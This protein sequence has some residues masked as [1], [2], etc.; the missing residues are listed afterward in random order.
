[1]KKIDI[2]K[3]WLYQ[4]YVIERLT[5]DDFKI[6]YGISQRTISRRIKEFN[7]ERE[8]SSWNSGLAGTGICKAPPKCFKKGHIPWN[9]DSKGL[10]RPNKT[11]FKK[12][13]S[14]TKG[15]FKKRDP[16][17]TGD[18]NKR[19]KGGITPLNNK[20]RHCDEYVKWRQGCMNR[21]NFT[22]QHCNKRGGNLTVHH[23]KP[24]RKIVSENKIDTFEEAL[25]CEELWDLN[26]GVTLCRTCHKK[27]DKNFNLKD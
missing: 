16:R 7:L 13:H 2:D 6:L 8:L 19:W 22:C 11:S 4:K 18:A 24:F 27:I 12:G 5:R 17:I 26:N 25:S 1:M 3:D 10:C 23:D 14:M 21:D 20:I 15:S 9:K